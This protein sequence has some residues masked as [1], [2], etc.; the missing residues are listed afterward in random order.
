MYLNGGAPLLRRPAPPYLAFVTDSFRD[1]LQAALAPNYTIDRELTG[2]GMSR[3]FV[4]V[5]H[6]LQRTVVVKVLRP[7]LAA[8]VNR[9][10][11][12]REI[13]LAAQLQHPHIVP[14]LSAGE[15]GDLIWYTMPFVE[16]ESLRE[17]M[18]RRG[19]Y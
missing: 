3:V 16:G 8:G 10:R 11:F 1:Q 5:E 6:A 7:D 12:R 9:E 18:V 14:V 19:P 17:G 13:M 4:A 2:G 15:R